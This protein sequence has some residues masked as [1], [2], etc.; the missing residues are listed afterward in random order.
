[1]RESHP[2]LTWE[3]GC[4]KARPNKDKEQSSSTKKSRQKQTTRM[5]KQSLSHQPTI[6]SWCPSFKCL[7]TVE[8]V[9]PVILGDVGE[10][11]RV[12]VGVELGRVQC[13]RHLATRWARRIDEGRWR[14]VGVRGM[15]LCRT[16]TDW[17]GERGGSATRRVHVNTY[18][19]RKLQ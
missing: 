8:W 9:F 13:A 5:P 7:E 6:Q 10:I 3:G 14:R 11:N 2:C 19:V 17:W 18:S 15:F 16:H 12:R 1:M 4:R